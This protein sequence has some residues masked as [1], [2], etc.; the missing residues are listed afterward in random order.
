MCDIVLQSKYGRANWFVPTCE[1]PTSEIL[2]PDPGLCVYEA[3][4]VV[5]CKAWRF[6]IETSEVEHLPNPTAAAKIVQK[7]IKYSRS[8]L[9]FSITSQKKNSRMFFR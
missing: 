4:L 8:S 7:Q 1:S 9:Q 3:E 6:Q 2:P 5:I